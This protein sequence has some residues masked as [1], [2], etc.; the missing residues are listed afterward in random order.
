MVET[1]AAT[2]CHSL[3]HRFYWAY[4]SSDAILSFIIVSVLG[5]VS[6]NRVAVTQNID[7]ADG[8]SSGDYVNENI[9]KHG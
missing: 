8:P 3:V 6:L 9:S 1:G 5:R 2:F 4:I 7:R